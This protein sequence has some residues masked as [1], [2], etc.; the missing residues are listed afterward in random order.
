MDN[1]LELAPNS[2]LQ[3]FSPVTCLMDVLGRG[4]KMTLSS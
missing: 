4:K 3:I 2:F 1:L